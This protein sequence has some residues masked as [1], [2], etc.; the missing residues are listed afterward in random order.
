MI[1]L[2]IEMDCKGDYA[3]KVNIIMPRLINA[4]YNDE[5]KNAYKSLTIN[6]LVDIFIDFYD[7]TRHI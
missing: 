6:V 7:K 1:L 5:W 3:A 2:E 4:D